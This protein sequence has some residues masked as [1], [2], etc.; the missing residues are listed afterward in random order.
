MDYLFKSYGK[1]FL[2]DNL[3]MTQTYKML[4]VIPDEILYMLNNTDVLPRPA[5]VQSTIVGL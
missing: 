1:A 3:D 2:I 4:F 5:G